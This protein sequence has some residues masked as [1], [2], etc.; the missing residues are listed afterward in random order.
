M[1]FVF[2]FN[3]FIGNRCHTY[4]VK[5]FQN[6]CNMKANNISAGNKLQIF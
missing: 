5:S 3:N 6:V 1:V 2:S 4:D